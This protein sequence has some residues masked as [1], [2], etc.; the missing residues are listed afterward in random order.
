MHYVTALKFARESGRVDAIAM[1][2]LKIASLEY[3][4]N[5]PQSASANARQALDLFR[6][7]GMKREQAEAEALLAKME[8]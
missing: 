6:R 5:Q 7:L 1:A 4:Q 2:L 3:T 8:A